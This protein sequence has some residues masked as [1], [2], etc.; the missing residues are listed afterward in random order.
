MNASVAQTIVRILLAIVLCLAAGFWGLLVL[1]SD[2]PPAQPRAI[3]F[4]YLTGGHLLAGFFV[5]FLLPLRWRF[6]IAVAW[7]AIVVGL[8]GLLSVASRSHGGSTLGVPLSEEIAL[9]VFALVIVPAAAAMGGY[10]GSL[11]GRK[12]PRNSIKLHAAHGAAKAS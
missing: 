6:S 10:A 3:W 5:G 11:V 2:L 1:F 7:G 9:T 12:W 8:L 4:V